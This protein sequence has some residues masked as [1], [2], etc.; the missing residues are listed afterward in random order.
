MKSIDADSFSELEDIY[1]NTPEIQIT[2]SF[3]SISKNSS[4]DT[5]AKD[6]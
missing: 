1:N 2:K 4:N 6:N 5:G 3:E